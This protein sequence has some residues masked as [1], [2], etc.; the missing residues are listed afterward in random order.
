MRAHDDQADLLFLGD[1]SYD[2]V[3][4]GAVPHEA[5]E[6]DSPG[7]GLFFDPGHVGLCLGYFVLH[8]L[9]RNGINLG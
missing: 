9:G 1:F 6:W 7:I 3:G 5:F 2:V 8:H 4:L